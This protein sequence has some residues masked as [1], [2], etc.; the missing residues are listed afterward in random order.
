MLDYPED[1]QALMSIIDSYDQCFPELS[2]LT[3]MNYKEITSLDLFRDW[4]I[5]PEKAPNFAF[6]VQNSTLFI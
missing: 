3:A 5:S 4:A 2:P 1:L 6:L